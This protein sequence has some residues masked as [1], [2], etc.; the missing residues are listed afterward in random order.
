MGEPPTEFKYTDDI[1]GYKNAVWDFLL[2]HSEI[3]TT[4]KVFIKFHTDGKKNFENRVIGRWKY[5]YHRE[6]VG[7]KAERV[8]EQKR[9]YKERKAI[10]EKERKAIKRQRIIEKRNEKN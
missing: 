2:E 10:E 1:I 9:Q 7:A 4:G 8:K 3:T 5:N 6:D